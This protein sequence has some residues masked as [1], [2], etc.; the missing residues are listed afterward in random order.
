MWSP[1]SRS[2]LNMQTGESQHPWECCRVSVEAAGMRITLGTRGGTQRQDLAHSPAKEI[3]WLERKRKYLPWV[4]K[5]EPNHFLGLYMEANETQDVVD[6]HWGLQVTGQPLPHSQRRI[7]R[8]ERWEDRAQRAQGWSRP[9]RGQGGVQQQQQL[10][11]AH[12]D[13]SKESQLQEEIRGGPPRRAC[14]DS[15]D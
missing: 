7:K 1:N 10:L 2:S 5:G 15:S 8:R 3:E 14:Q 11:G 12:W 9:G 13:P 6:R 4:F